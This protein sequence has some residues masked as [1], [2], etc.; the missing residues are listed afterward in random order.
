MWAVN[1][2]ALQWAPSYDARSDVMT[3]HDTNDIRLSVLPLSVLVLPK[4]LS[5]LQTATPLSPLTSGC[6]QWIDPRGQQQITAVKVDSP[7]LLSK[8]SE[9][10]GRIQET[11]QVGQQGHQLISAKKVYCRLR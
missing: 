7:L 5:Q 8:S 4:K 2:W 1:K 6:R 3:R 10:Q 9:M 11:R